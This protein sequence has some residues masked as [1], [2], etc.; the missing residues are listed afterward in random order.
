MYGLM[1]SKI[2]ILSLDLK[3]CFFVAPWQKNEFPESMQEWAETIGYETYK[4]QMDW[5]GKNLLTYEAQVKKARRLADRLLVFVEIVLKQHSPSK[6]LWF[7]IK[8][9]LRR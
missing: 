5:T 8:N 7:K 6:R 1:S 2:K 4:G 3:C 9:F